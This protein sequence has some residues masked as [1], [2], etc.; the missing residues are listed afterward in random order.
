MQ[1]AIH[2]T[3]FENVEKKLNRIAKKCEKHGNDFVFEIV[4]SEIREEK[5]GDEVIAR[6]KFIIVEVEGVAKVDNWEFIAVLDIH[7]DGNIIRRCNNDVELPERFKNSENICEHCNTKRPRNKLY[8]I[9]N[10]ETGEFKQVGGNCLNLYANGLSMEYVASWLDGITELEEND[11][12]FCSG[13]K[14]YY[15]VRE[16]VNYANIIINKVGYLKNDPYGNDTSTKSLVSNLIHRDVFAS[17]IEKRVESLNN[18]LANHLFD[19]R[20]SVA[21][22][23]ADNADEVD[24]ILYYYKSLPDNSEFNHNV[25]IMIDEE[26]VPYNYLGYI[27]YLPQGYNKHIEREV[28]RASRIAEKHEHWGEVGKRYRNIDIKNVRGVAAYETAYGIMRIWNIVIED[29]TVLTWKTSNT[30]CDDYSTIDFTVKAHGEY[31]GIK[32]TEVTRC[33]I[34]CKEN[35]AA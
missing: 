26:Y 34:K 17:T 25:K 16:L 10:T 21:D 4:G 13:G 31:K 22:F 29:G 9:R 3:L 20:F 2:E 6:H 15:S 24:A 19:V 32:Q 18:E 30:I 28:E 1:Y 12:V 7:A 5:K 23:L 14:T 35:K 11:G 27:C 33:K 8:I